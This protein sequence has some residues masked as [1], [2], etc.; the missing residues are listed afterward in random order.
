MADDKSSNKL[1]LTHIAP[2]DQNK[3]ISERTILPFIH[4]ALNR[5]ALTPAPE[6][7]QMSLDEIARAEFHP[8]WESHAKKEAQYS[9]T[10]NLKTNN[11]SL[12]GCVYLYSKPVFEIKGS[13]TDK[14][15][16]FL[17]YVQGFVLC[18]RV[19]YEGVFLSNVSPMHIMEGKFQPYEGE[20]F[21]AIAAIRCYKRALM[22]E[23]LKRLVNETDKLDIFKDQIIN[24]ARS[25]EDEHAREVTGIV[26]AYMVKQLPLIDKDFLLGVCVVYLVGQG[27]NRV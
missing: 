8:K 16:R 17:E 20:D 22:P 24:D 13:P 10:Y 25:I 21:M 4:I 11:M 7:R 5:V 3:L 2:P 9:A 27:G 19:S 26:A 1:N 12:Q 6:H 15:G 18:R 14:E 23:E